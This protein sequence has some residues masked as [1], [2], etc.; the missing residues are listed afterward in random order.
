MDGI[1]I[2]CSLEV[3]INDCPYTF[4]QWH[5]KSHTIAPRC[6]LPMSGLGTL[7]AV[8]TKYTPFAL[9]NAFVCLLILYAPQ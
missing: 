8:Y 4:K 7:V 3:L 5:T 9:G 1:D 2:F 6:N